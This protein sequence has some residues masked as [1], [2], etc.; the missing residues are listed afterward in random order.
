MK[1]KCQGRRVFTMKSDVSAHQ[2]DFLIRKGVGYWRTAGHDPWLATPDEN[3]PYTSFEDYCRRC[4][5][6]GSLYREVT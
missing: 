4:K 5:G 3:R 6:M 1:N 2:Y